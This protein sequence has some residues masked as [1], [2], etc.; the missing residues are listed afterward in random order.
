M[1]IFALFI[2]LIVLLLIVIF[3]RFVSFELVEL[4]N[5]KP[6]ITLGK[7]EKINLNSIGDKA[8][9][10]QSVDSEKFTIDK[11]AF[12]LK[13]GITPGIKWN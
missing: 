4:E 3:K 7:S 2:I 12:R 11:L 10:S 5:Y 1:S 13:D 6:H 9:Q 8:K